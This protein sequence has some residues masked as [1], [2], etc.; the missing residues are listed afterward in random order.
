MLYVIKGNI[1]DQRNMY[2]WHD[3]QLA[4]TSV[5][6]VLPPANAHYR[7][8]HLHTWLKKWLGTKVIMQIT[9]PHTRSAMHS[10]TTHKL[11][12]CEVTID[13]NKN[14]VWVERGNTLLLTSV[15]EGS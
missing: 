5:M 9:F 6:L 14:S 1:G 10:E 13:R 2:T 11:K 15:T 8:V 12:A 3:K 4:Y 7:Y